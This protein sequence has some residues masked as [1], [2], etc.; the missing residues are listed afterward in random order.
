MQAESGT[1]K[2]KTRERSK[3]REESKTRAGW[4]QVG[5]GCGR[6]GGESKGREKKSEGG[7]KKGRRE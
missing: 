6:Y 1:E 3:G 4:G 5:V 2:E 7:R